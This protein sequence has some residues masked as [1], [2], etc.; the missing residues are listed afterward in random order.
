MRI[1]ALDIGV[2]TTDVMLIE[3]EKNLENCIK[4][5]LPSAAQIYAAAVAKATKARK[6][7]YIFGDTVGGGPFASA[8]KRHIAAGLKVTM[9]PQAAFSI[10]NDLSEVQTL[11]I[12]IADHEY[13][14]SDFDGCALWLQE[15]RLIPI[16]D[17]LKKSGERGEADIIALAVQDHGISPKGISNRIT[18]IDRFRN[19]L[20][21]DPRLESLMYSIDQIPGDFIRMR[22]AAERAK[23]EA[24]GAKIFVMDTSPVAALGCLADPQIHQDD[25]I[26]AVNFGNGH[27]LAVLFDHGKVVRGFEAHTRQFENGI[28][29]RE[30][31]EDFIAGQLTDERVFGDGGHG[32]FNISQRP[33]EPDQILVTGP[34]RALIE[35]TKLNFRYAAPA[36]DVMMTGPIGLYCAIKSRFFKSL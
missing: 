11:G 36:G 31:L 7:L 9:T 12:N 33:L 17:F 4:F 25:C 8:I 15:V 14:P 29:L 21:K 24:P 20:S 10:R 35:T 30:Y 23:K 6:E 34:R 26:L 16:F 3:P 2:G 27:S 28:A 18:R 19:L 1:L 5:V 32:L 13:P 22:S